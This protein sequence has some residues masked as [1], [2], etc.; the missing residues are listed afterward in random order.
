M[1][2]RKKFSTS[3]AGTTRR[4]GLS[5]G[6]LVVLFAV[7]LASRVIYLTADPPKDLSWSLGVFFD[8]GIYNHNARN[9]IL[10]GHWKLD[11]WND[12][13][14]SAIST[15]LKYAV[16]G[17]IGIG[18]AQIRLFSIAFSVLSLLWVYLIAKNSYNRATG[19]LALLFFGTNY[20][21]TM[22]SRLGMQDTQTLT[23]FILGFY[24]WQKA[25][26]RPENRDSLIYSAL[27][28]IVFFISYTFKNLFLYLLPTPFVALACYT[29]IHWSNP[30]L[31]KKLSLTFVA[32]SGGM[33][34]AFLFWWFTFYAPNR[35]YITQFG[36]FFTRQQMFPIIS[37][38]QFW[39]NLYTTPF[40]DVFSRTPVVLAGSLAWIGIL[41]YWTGTPK[42]TQLHP[43]DMFAFFWFFAAFVFIGIIGYRPPRYFLPIIPP[44]CVL[45]ARGVYGVFTA[46]RRR[47]AVIPRAHWSVFPIIMLWMTLII[48]RCLIPWGVRYFLK[49]A[50][51]PFR[52]P[53]SQY[54]VSSLLIA[55]VLLIFLWSAP[56]RS[57]IFRVQRRLFARTVP[58]HFSPVPI[59]LGIALTGLS[60]YMDGK[61][62]YGWARNPEYTVRQT[63]QDI[64]QY[65]GAEGYIA[66]MDAPGVA[67]D[68][69]YK[70]LISWDGYV[71]FSPNPIT[72]YGLTHLF[73]GD[74]TGFPEKDRYFRNYP[75]E[76]EHATLLQRYT[77]KDTPFLLYSLIEPT[78]KDTQI[79][80][81]R[82]RL[83]VTMRVKNQDVRH[84]KEM[85]ANWRLYAG[86]FDQ[87]SEPMSIGQGV[88][89][90][91]EAGQEIDFSISGQI[92]PLYQE[93]YR[94]F[95]HWGAE[96]TLIDE[97]E[98]MQRRI[99]QIVSDTDAIGN[100]AVYQQ[101]GTEGFLAFGN[102]RSYGPGVYHANFRIKIN[103]NSPVQAV[104]R[105][106][107]VDEHGTV[108]LNQQDISGI[109]IVH[110]L[111]Y[112]NLILPYKLL[113]SA[114]YV[115][116]RVYSY[117]MVDVW[118]DRVFSEGQSGNWF[119][120]S[121]SSLDE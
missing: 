36:Q 84:G 25:I 37:L 80:T 48:H 2:A 89:R 16:F 3:M 17:I 76:M 19:M 94:L 32:L 75:Q 87:N 106:E 96:Q 18:R 29:V 61:A 13:Y 65:I 4:I 21:S 9:Q 93:P 54:L 70:T 98:H 22:Y 10:F 100:R 113:R 15:W 12:Y 5:T 85:T 69:P 120:V 72:T 57:I 90:Q 7:F 28:G 55:G 46:S 114:A 121:I 38:A 111:T 92:S 103:D 73:L 23:V 117:G 78:L 39:H 53:L 62:Y 49:P 112:Q 108:L 33:T 58:G 119:P 42:R 40:F 56:V 95:I 66:G 30:P 71:N 116:F 99:G 27:A 24:L 11:E 43:S 34:S 31:R 8:E 83:R 35:A 45:T 118:V 44:M 26:H 68:T 115:E 81:E 20:L 101:A 67:F 109:D 104:L 88:K 14:Y 1:P 82:D 50:S 41:I 51:N 77:I 107:V 91:M 6:I 102:Y 59:F 64:M 105:I 74:T 110:P 63:G 52:L 60:L 79:E 86:E 97:A 47:E